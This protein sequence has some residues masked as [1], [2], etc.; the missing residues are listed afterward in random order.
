MLHARLLSYLDEV[1]A[2]RLNVAPSAVSRQILAFEQELGTPMFQRTPRK[3]M[4]MAAG[5]S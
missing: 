3:L 1:A 4:L 5:E 2:D